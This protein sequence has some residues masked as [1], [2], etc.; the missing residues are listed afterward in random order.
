[1]TKFYERK[2]FFEYIF[3]IENLDLTDKRS[4]K[5]GNIKL[6][7][8][9]EYQYSKSIGKIKSLLDKNTYY[10]AHPN[11][12]DNVI[13]RTR[14]IYKRNKNKVCGI[15]EKYGYVEDAYFKALSDVK[16]CINVLKLYRNEG[17]QDDNFL[18]RY[19]GIE[20]E[21]LARGVRSVFIEAK[22]SENYRPTAEVYGSMRPFK[23]N[24]DRLEFMSN[25]GFDKIHRLLK[26]KR[27]NAL[28]KRIISAINWFGKS[29]N[30]H[31]AV[32][33]S[34][35]SVRMRKRI[36][37]GSL[38]I[39][40]ISEPERLLYC[41]IALE[42]LLLFSNKENKEKSVAER[43][44][45][46]IDGDVRPV[47]VKNVPITYHRLYKIRCDIVHGGRYYVER[48]DLNSIFDLT[49]NAI[50]SLIKKRRRNKLDN[51]IDFQNWLKKG[52]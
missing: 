1:M 28:D 8:Y 22:K 38:K 2:H 10:I 14:Q 30:S 26:Q 20:G 32:R 33:E 12:K 48:K 15:S 34:Y 4:L 6:I 42:G 40:G 23:I 51:V 41:I 7:K 16:T 25:N 35:K 45:R 47:I 31:I 13:K 52:S 18:G 5:I 49:Q 27:F 17:V 50:F 37:T 36:G 21:V 44:M 24:D 19:F 46:I 43:I 3:P 39:P 9:N 29:Y 11:A